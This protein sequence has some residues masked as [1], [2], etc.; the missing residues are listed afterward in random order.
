MKHLAIAL[1]ISTAVLLTGCGGMSGPPPATVAP[2]TASSP[3]A[4]VPSVAGNWQ[5]TATST[6]SGQ[7]AL[8]F[9]GSISQT[10]SVAIAAL[11][12]DGSSCFHQLTTMSLTASMTA[13]HSTLTS[14]AVDGQVVTFTGDFSQQTTD[15][16]IPRTYFNGTYA[17]SGGCAGGDHGTLT[18]EV[19]SLT[20]ARNWGGVLT[21]SSQK[22]FNVSGDFHQGT[23]S[24]PEGSFAA[25]GTAT[26]DTPCVSA[27]TLNPGSFPAGSFVL[28]TLVS[29]EIKTNN[30]TVNILGTVDPNTELIQGAYTIS[31]GTCDETGTASVALTG[32]WDY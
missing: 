21:N 22:K 20:D 5:F 8:S 10:G 12:A 14:A 11:H 13:A 6:V 24:S 29:I 9:A 4:S 27:A 32:Q 15:S 19:V 7:P 26:F 30:G 2:K 3:T 25:T 23:L 18:G 28:G 31:G 1:A 16:G 17:V